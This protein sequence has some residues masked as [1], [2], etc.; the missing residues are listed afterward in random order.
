MLDK[1]ARK[2]ILV[3]AKGA[4]LAPDTINQ[5]L[6][7]AERKQAVQDSGAVYLNQAQKAEQLGVSRFTIAK[8]TRLGRL[9]PVEIL[10]GLIRYRRDELI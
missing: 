8:L 1:T 3:T 10:P 6:A 9:H 2:I 7:V 4:G 5:M